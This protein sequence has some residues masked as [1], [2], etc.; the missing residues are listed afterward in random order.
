[1]TTEAAYAKIVVFLGDRRVEATEVGQEL[2]KHRMMSSW[3]GEMTL[4]ADVL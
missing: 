1:M 2:F 4:M 3:A